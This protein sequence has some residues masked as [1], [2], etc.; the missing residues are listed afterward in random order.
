VI[1]TPDYEIEENKSLGDEFSKRCCICEKSLKKHESD[2][3]ERCRK[4]PD[5]SSSARSLVKLG[6]N[7]FN[8]FN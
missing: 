8:N 1:A 4:L 2:R 3:C 5:L 6:F 7:L